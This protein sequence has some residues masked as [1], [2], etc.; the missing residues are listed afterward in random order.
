MHYQGERVEL[1]R[2]RDMKR[3]HAISV[4]STAQG[5]VDEW[6]VSVALT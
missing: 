1:L 6:L 5:R 3:V 2:L 4:N